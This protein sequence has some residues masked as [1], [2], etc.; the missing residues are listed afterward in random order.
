MICNITPQT[1]SL[2]LIQARGESGLG[3][4]LAAKVQ[5]EDGFGVLIGGEEA[6]LAD[7]EAWG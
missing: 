7:R 5:R 6:R 4:M 1:Q 2:G 3:W